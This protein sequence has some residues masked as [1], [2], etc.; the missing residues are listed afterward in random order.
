MSSILL[1]MF[2]PALAIAGFASFN[3]DD[4]DDDKTDATPDTSTDAQ[5]NAGDTITGTDISDFIVG[6][7]GD[8]NIY[9]GD[10][11]DVGE[12][13]DDNTYADAT[14]A[15]ITGDLDSFDS[16][17]EGF[18]GVNGISGDD[19]IDLGHGNDA[20]TGGA[21]DDT[22]R[23]NLGAD[24]I[25]DTEGADSLDGG[26]GDDVLIAV[27][28]PDDAS[29]VLNGGAN[30][31]LLWGDG[32]DTM[33][34]GS[35][36]DLF[37][38][39]WAPGEDMASITDFDTV[40]DETESEFLQI[41][42]S[43]I[44][45]NSIFALEDTDDGAI[46]SIDGEPV[47]QFDGKD[48]IDLESFKINVYDIDADAS[49]DIDLSD[50]ETDNQA[51]DPNDE[52][53]E[54]AVYGTDDDDYIMGMEGNDTVF[55]AAGND[56][57][58]GE[59]GDDSLEGGDGLDIVDGNDGDDTVIGDAGMDFLS[60]GPGDDLIY[61]GP[62]DDLV[63]ERSAWDVN[64]T[65]E[66]SG[67][68]TIYGGSGN[69]VLADYRGSDLIEGGAGNDTI[70][71]VQVTLTGVQTLYEAPDGP[72]TLLGGDGDD[73]IVASDGDIVSGGAGADIIGN[74]MGDGFDPITITDF[75]PAEDILYLNGDIVDP[76]SLTLATGTSATTTL[77]QVDGV[78]HVILQ[79]LAP[80]QVGTDAIQFSA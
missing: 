48:A 77:V 66:D 31:D 27:D 19:Y 38:L 44:S 20:G 49:Y 23:G 30:D 6:T 80:T 70:S 22:I 75:D 74:V 39:N 51:P 58:T 71:S 50:D 57:L 55:S 76:A 18:F 61:G 73:A 25:A 79:G 34:G 29:D 69:D 28:G 5:A 68:D 63:I 43:G 26:Y 62:G 4:D 65:E 32:G 8:D 14:E 1:L 10:G 36:E 2:L 54:G 16:L 67:D 72:D 40:D 59:N 46:F 35:G 9:A 60:G 21:G 42:A 78:T 53:I 52:R 12:T 24:L 7:T 41:A 3:N 13:I 17:S 47:V 15:L 11:N 45:A 64:D 37:V 33:T 56:T